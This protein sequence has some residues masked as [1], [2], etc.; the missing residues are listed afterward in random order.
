MLFEIEIEGHAYVEAESED[1][2]IT[3]FKRECGYGEL[4]DLC[5]ISVYANPT[6]I[7]GD[8]K[9]TEPYGSSDGKSVGQIF[10]EKL[11][12]DKAEYDRKEYLDKHHAPLFREVT[13]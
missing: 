5:D 4:R 10:D 8:W 9:N 1:D 3:V 7:W 12:A 2:A 13:T 6:S 11:A